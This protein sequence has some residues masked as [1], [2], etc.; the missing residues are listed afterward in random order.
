[1]VDAKVGGRSGNVSS[2]AGKKGS[3]MLGPYG[4][5]KAGV[6]LLTQ[7]M[8]AE[9]GP[10]GI[11]VNAV[12][13]GTVDTELVNPNG[14]YELML[15]GKEAAQAHIER[16]I[17]LGRLQSPEEIAASICW[18][19]SDDAAAITGEAVNTSARSEEHT[20]ELQSLMRISYAVLCL[21]KKKTTNNITTSNT[22]Q[23]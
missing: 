10:S 19:L 20:S 23:I 2:Q 5:A 17:P 4:A 16:T 15:G 11:S 6:I 1:M 12:C 13:P 7:G 22:P 3:P 9:L 21:K 8:A 18:L 14:M